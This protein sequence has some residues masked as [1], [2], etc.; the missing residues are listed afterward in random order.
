MERLQL[1]NSVSKRK[2][3]VG[4]FAGL[5]RTDTI[6]DGEFEEMENLTSSSY[7]AAEPRKPRGDRLKTILRPHGMLW[8][9]GLAY[10]DGTKF[11]YK[12]EEIGEVSDTDKQLAGMGAYIIIYPDKKIFNTADGS[13][14]NIEYT[15]QQSAAATIAP[16]YDASTYTKI[17]CT[18]IG[19]GFKAGDGV[20]ISGCSAE[21][22]NGSKIIQSCEADF[23]VVIGQIQEEVTQENGIKVTR[24]AP[25]LDFICE[26]DNR[27]WGC[28]SKN[29]EIYASKLG[30]PKNWNCFEGVSTDSYAATVGS[31]GDFTGCISFMG[32]V[33]FFKEECIH[34]LYGNKPSNIQI[35]TYPF[36][37][38]A[39]GCEK[40][41]CVVNE[42]LYYVSRNDVMQ[43]DGAIPE[44]ASVKLG[45]LDAVGA[46]GESY[47]GKYYV[48]ITEEN[49]GTNLYV[50]DT[51]RLLWHRE[52]DTKFL[53]AEYGEGSFYYIAGAELRTIESA[54]GAERVKWSATSGA[55][56]E[57][58]M[59]RKRVTKIQFMA[60]MG[61]DTLF[62][63]FV[64]YDGSP[65][66]QRVYTKRE[67]DK[68][69]DEICIK[70]KKCNYYKWRIK[71]IGQF[72]LYGIAKTVQIAGVR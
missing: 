61:R 27:L 63:L 25:D 24:T 16:T 14:E 7:P 36:R 9:N 37:G 66:W 3:V 65:I 11:Y 17:T 58:N 64:S 29:H 2:N 43:Y 48:S 28:S 35:N 40:S 32:Y 18:G 49:A 69:S 6:A 26:S 60:E 54:A 45:T 38:V 41:L 59:N 47:Q 5:N 33:L 19:A 13:F 68:C 57:G 52:D 31:D 56:F 51:E 34:K 39:K 46:A 1:L 44:S 55:Q 8:K 10:I 62:E 21:V 15:W 4:V 50:F 22:L 71:G 70:P 67:T 20:T 42:T 23:I 12:D 53:Y 30:D 72:K